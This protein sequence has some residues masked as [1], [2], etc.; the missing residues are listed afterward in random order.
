MAVT[1]EAHY[2]LHMVFARPIQI[3]FLSGNHH[4]REDN[5]A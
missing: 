2:L 5:F 1:L 3:F 4:Y